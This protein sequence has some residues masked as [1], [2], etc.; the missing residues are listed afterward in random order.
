MVGSRSINL[1]LS[2]FVIS[3]KPLC[4]PRLPEI[5]RENKVG[6]Y[7]DN[8]LKGRPRVLQCD[9]TKA[10]LLWSTN[11]YVKMSTFSSIHQYLSPRWP[12]YFTRTPPVTPRNSSNSSFRLFLL[13]P[14]PFH[15]LPSF[16]SSSLR[17][18][19]LICRVP[20]QS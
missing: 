12:P 3:A 14:S 4:L 8:R 15:L 19:N 10:V 11:K 18:P 5:R 6:G 1:G 7:L 2:A 9:V 16:M 20:S 17:L 13:S